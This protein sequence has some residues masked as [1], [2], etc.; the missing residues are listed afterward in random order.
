[1]KFLGT[2]LLRGAVWCLSNPKA[3]N[4]GLQEI[5]GLVAEVHKKQNLQPKS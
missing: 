1:M 4:A 3:A 5:L 2:L